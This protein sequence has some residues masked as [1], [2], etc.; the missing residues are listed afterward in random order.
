MGNAQCSRCCHTLEPTFEGEHEEFIE[1]RDPDTNQAIGVVARSKVE[2]RPQDQVGDDLFELTA[3]GGLQQRLEKKL[4]KKVAKKAKKAK[5]KPNPYK[6]D[7]D[8]HFDTSI[9]SLEDDLKALANWQIELTA[10]YKECQVLKRKKYALKLKLESY[11]TWLVILSIGLV[12]AISYSIGVT[13]WLVNQI[14]ESTD[15]MYSRG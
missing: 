1:V 11:K 14:Q 4:Q 8:K 15:E 2:R 12:S 9:T 3:L 13:V 10:V 5:D 7:A 6:T